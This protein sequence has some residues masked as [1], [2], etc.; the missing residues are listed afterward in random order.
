MQVRSGSPSAPDWMTALAFFHSGSVRDWNITP[1][2][3]LCFRAAAII[4]SASL[5]RTAIG[6]SVRT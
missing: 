5:A 1:S 6:F 2:F 3:T 4:L